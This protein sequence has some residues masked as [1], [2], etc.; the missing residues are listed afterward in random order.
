MEFF[1]HKVE[2][3]GVCP[4]NELDML[5][6]IETCGRICY[7]SE[8]KIDWDNESYLKFYKMLYNSG[9]VSAIEHSNI[10]VEMSTSDD[11]LYNSL[12]TSFVF[13]A[14]NKLSHFR[15]FERSLLPA[16]DQKLLVISANIR[17]WDEFFSYAKYFVAFDELSS[18]L[19]QQY[20]NVFARMDK[21]REDRLEMFGDEAIKP[22]DGRVEFRIVS[23]KEQLNSPTMVL[24]DIPQYTFHVLTD[25]GIS[26]EIVRHRV[27]S[28]SQESTRYINYRSRGIQ[29][30]NF[31]I[32]TEMQEKYLVFCEEI[33]STYNKLIELGVKPQFARNVLPNAIKTEL[34][35]TGRMSGY[36]H[37]I[38]LRKSLAAHP[39]IRIVATAMEQVF[40]ELEKE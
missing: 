16:I 27:F 35:M 17:A 28:Y 6:H 30:V 2:F 5:K 33:E 21:Y 13:E 22:L 38:E 25:R 36:E 19:Q 11:F 26:H 20:P 4:D 39:S 14:A 10:V 9:H 31:P 24:E 12:V 18:F 8:H 34:T 23:V 3:L 29:F 7:K 37:F 1:D 15:F 32:P 40:N